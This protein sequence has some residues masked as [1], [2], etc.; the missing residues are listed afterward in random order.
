MNTN[1]TSNTDKDTV[2][3]LLKELE[4]EGIQKTADIIKGSNENTTAVLLDIMKKGSDTFTEKTGRN[5]TYSEMRQAW[6]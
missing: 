6:G 2:K 4:K 5:M 3:T 1:T